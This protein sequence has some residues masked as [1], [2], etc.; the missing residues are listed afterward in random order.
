MNDLMRLE[1]ILG[2]SMDCIVEIDLQ[3]VVTSVNRTCAV[4]FEASAA[5]LVGQ[6]WPSLWPDLAAEKIHVALMEALSGNA[7]RLTAMRRAGS[8]E[9]R[10]WLVSTSP[11][12]GPDGGLEG[13]VA[14]SRDVTDRFQIERALETIN[15]SLERRLSLVLA[16]RD[17]AA[18]LNDD[19]DTRL[20]EAS[21]ASQQ[22]RRDGEALQQRLALALSAQESAEQSARQAQKGEAVGQLVAGVAHDFNNMLQTAIIGLS[23]VTDRPERLQEN[24]RKLLGYSSE[25]LRHASTVARRLLGFAR[26][27]RFE[28]EALDLQE[29]VCSMAELIGHSMG[30]RIDLQI[31]PCGHACAAFVDRHSVEQALINLC[32]NARD[33]SEG[34]GAIVIRFGRITVAEQARDA[35]RAVGEYVT[36]AVC[37]SGTGMDEMTKAR[38]FE[39]YFTTKPEGQGTGLGLAQV[40]ALLRQAGGF[41]DIESTVRVGTVVTLAFPQFSPVDTGP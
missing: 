37:D 40:Y 9:E 35:P 5:A 14:L 39:P 23:A 33:A 15:T 11:L 41:V 8:G 13:V 18:A 17:R 1:Q 22:Q 21:S 34:N 38:L 27:H 36:L 6:E 7:T 32:I 19:L 16:Q 20:R 30:N 4:M 26:I 25:A 29:V 12:T 28:P 3:G 10:W 24:Q 2:L 31:Q